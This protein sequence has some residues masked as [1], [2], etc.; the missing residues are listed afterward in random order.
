MQALTYLTYDQIDQ[1]KWDT[2]LSYAKNRLI[3]AESVYLNNMCD[4]WDAIVSDGYT[5][6][7]P[8]P[9]RKKWGITYLYQP[10]FFQQGGVFSEM[11]ITQDILVAFLRKAME[12]IRFAET[13]LNF[14]NNIPVNV[15]GLSVNQRNNFILPLGKG[16]EKLYQSFDPYITQRIRKAAKQDLIYKHSFDTDS[17]ISLYKSLYQQRLPSFSDDD[18]DR[19]GRLCKYYLNEKRLFIRLVHNFHSED[20]LA[21]IL[22]LKDD[23]R[24]YNMASCLLPEGKKKLANYFLLNEVIREFSD[25]NILLDFEGSDIPGI[26]Y[27]YEKFSE[28]NEPYP[29]IRYN[30]LPPPLNWIKG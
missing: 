28:Q 17:A 8:L 1:A 24:L 9:W 14:G 7:M 27:F 18:Y 25:K 5:Y 19:F 10:S 4:H 15:Q 26:A 16:Y 12:H 30:F 6:I 11:D 13:T 20:P 29:F 21:L 2:R 23:R 22:L 3:Y